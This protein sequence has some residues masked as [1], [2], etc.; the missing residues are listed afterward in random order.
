VFRFAGIGLADL[1]A[2]LPLPFSKG[3]D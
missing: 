1:L 2:F 3:E